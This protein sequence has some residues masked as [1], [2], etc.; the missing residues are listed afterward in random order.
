M[1][2]LLVTSVIRLIPCYRQ[3]LLLTIIHF[4]V[5][6]KLGSGNFLANRYTTRWAR[7]LVLLILA[8]NISA[9]WGWH[10]IDINSGNKLF[11][12]CFSRLVLIDKKMSLRSQSRNVRYRIYT[13]IIVLGRLVV[14]GTILA[15]QCFFVVVRGWRL[16]FICLIVD[17]T[18]FRS[19]LSWKL[20][21]VV[22][23]LPFPVRGSS[24]RWVG[25]SWASITRGRYRMIVQYFFAVF[26]RRLMLIS[27]FD[28]GIIRCWG[29]HCLRLFLSIIGDDIHHIRSTRRTSSRFL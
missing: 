28:W 6:W 7:L 11:V 23:S 18:S 25:L 13:Y 17:C 12:Q 26:S 8:D 16:L 24:L 27:L 9:L 22:G 3:L 5:P 20:H 29:C 14:I 2:P 21:L 15:L 10:S 4:L 19:S 1:N